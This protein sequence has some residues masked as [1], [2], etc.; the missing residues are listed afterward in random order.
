[1]WTFLP[2]LLHKAGLAAANCLELNLTYS[3]CSGTQLTGL[4]IPSATVQRLLTQ[5]VQRSNQTRLTFPFLS[6]GKGIMALPTSNANC[7]RCLLWG[8]MICVSKRMDN[9]PRQ[10]RCYRHFRKDQSNAGYSSAQLRM[11]GYLTYLR[12]Q[13]KLE[14]LVL[15]HPQ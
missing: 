11:Q 5:K 12:K 14:T 15:A 6:G 9:S 8:V 4:P 10:A 1:M 13:N 3:A 2:G 7:P